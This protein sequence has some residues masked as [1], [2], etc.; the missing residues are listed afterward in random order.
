MIE[1][2]LAAA[3]ASKQHKTLTADLLRRLTSAAAESR[4]S[5]HHR[6]TLRCLLKV[7]L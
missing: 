5:L 4:C 7:A 3:T 6:A 1:A 2:T